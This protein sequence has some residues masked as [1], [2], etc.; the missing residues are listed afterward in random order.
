VHVF[1]DKLRRYVSGPRVRFRRNTNIYLRSN[2]FTLPRRIRYRITY[3]FA[4]DPPPLY[5]IHIA[6]VYDKHGGVIP[7]ASRKS[8]RTNIYSRSLGRNARKKPPRPRVVGW[9]TAGRI[10][11]IRAKRNRGYRFIPTPRYRDETFGRDTVAVLSGCRFC[12]LFVKR[13]TR[14]L[15]FSTSVQNRARPT[16]AYT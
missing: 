5:I 7:A 13:R 10:A 11:F 6:R 8:R 12:V 16:R 9:K 3:T 4:R 1:F 15:E 14:L 2:Y